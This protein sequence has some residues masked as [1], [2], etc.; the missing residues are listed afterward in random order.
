MPSAN[1]FLS[2]FRKSA[3]AS[4]TGEIPESIEVQF[5]MRP[6]HYQPK[7]PMWK[8]ETTLPVKLAI[9]RIDGV[10]VHRDE[11]AFGKL[12]ECAARYRERYTGKSAGEVPGVQHARRL[13]RSI[14][15]EPTRRRPASE[16]LLNRALKDKPFPAINTLVDVGNW[17]SLD[18]LLP[19]C[20]YDADK[21]A[22]EV[23]VR[24]GREGES[25]LALNNREIHLTGRYVLADERGPFGSPITDSQRTAVRSD[26]R[27]AIL[28]IFAPRE[29]DSRQLREYA[30]VFSQRVIDF[31]GGKTARVEILNQ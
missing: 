13:F 11:G 26:T 5:V 17:C 31:C 25:Y 15:I 27:N 28:V 6:G 7:A 8:I 14:G 1:G 12:L 20:V 23:T 9:V 22:G 4:T 2:P 30:N 21:I 19:I 18:F 3:T 16:A 24:K 10:A 29:F